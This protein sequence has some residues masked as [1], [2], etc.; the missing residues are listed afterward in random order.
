MRP[1]VLGGS[2]ACSMIGPSKP[3]VFYHPKFAGNHFKQNMHATFAYAHFKFQTQNM[4][5]INSIFKCQVQN[6]LASAYN[7]RFINFYLRRSVKIK[8]KR[9]MVPCILGYIVAVQPVLLLFVQ[10]FTYT[11]RLRQF[12]I[13]F[14]PTIEL[15]LWSYM[16]LH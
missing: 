11:S 9:F 14:T 16:D 8:T 7:G 15:L 3:H 4:L 13:R 5:C 10:P 1:S 6:M 12:Y 2:M